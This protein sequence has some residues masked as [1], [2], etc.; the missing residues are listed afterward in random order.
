MS[1]PT[2]DRDFSHLPLS[3]RMLLAHALVDSAIAEAQASPV[4]PEQLEEIRRCDAAVDSGDM[5]CEAWDV[6]RKRLFPR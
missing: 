4:T 5:K 6:V 3:D 1:Q 2:F